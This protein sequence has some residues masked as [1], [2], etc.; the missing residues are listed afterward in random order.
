MS[1]LLIICA[2]L[3]MNDCRE[4]LF[5]RRASPIASSEW[6]GAVVPLCAGLAREFAHGTLAWA[7][8]CVARCNSCSC[9]AALHTRLGL[10]PLVCAGYRVDSVELLPATFRVAD[11]YA[12]NV[13]SWMMHCHVNHHIHGGMMALFE[14][15]FSCS[16]LLQRLSL[17]RAV[18]ARIALF[19]WIVSL[20]WFVPILAGTGARDDAKHAADGYGARQM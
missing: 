4:S 5:I 17:N 11:M 18:P 1:A 12:D 6:Q 7:D 15:S 13:G 14:A 9:L 19:V 3:P 20:V 8:S 2:Y 16:V 10:L